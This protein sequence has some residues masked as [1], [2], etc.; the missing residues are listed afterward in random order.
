[1]TASIPT[2]TNAPEALRRQ[3]FARQVASELAELAT[4]TA[5]WDDYIGEVE[6]SCGADGIR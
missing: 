1:M 5:A 6:V 2:T 3:R 4:N